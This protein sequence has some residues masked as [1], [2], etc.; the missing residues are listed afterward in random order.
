MGKD[1]RKTEYEKTPS[2]T[3]TG[4]FN[5]F[6]LQKIPKWHGTNGELV[7]E[8]NGCFQVQH[9][10]R[11]AG[12]ASGAGGKGLTECAAFTVIT[13]LDS[14]NG[15]TEEKRSPNRATDAATFYMT[16]KG[17]M[18]SDFGLAKGASIGSN[19]TYRSGAALK[20]DRSAIIGREEVKIVTGKMRTSSGQERLAQGGSYTGGG[21]IQLIAGNY[22]G[23]TKKSSVANLGSIVGKS[24]TK[25]L[26]SVPKGDNLRDLLEKIVDN[27]NNLNGQILDNRRSIIEIGTAF[28]SHMHLGVCP[29]GPVV[30]TPSPM[31]GPS[32]SAVITQFTKIADSIIF[33]ANQ[34]VTKLSYL[35]SNF[36]DYINSK[37]VSTT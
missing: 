36:P 22:T 17:Q 6:I 26:Q 34:G 18:T 16:Q 11:S 20:S 14:A 27:L 21:T 2:G 15:P 12:L 13:G 25:Y 30:T 7:N 1:Q 8:F 24:Q 5:N 19:Q 4:Y 3:R 23:T 33:S 35:D 37:N 32:I 31:I 9:R 28:N 10:D 29:V